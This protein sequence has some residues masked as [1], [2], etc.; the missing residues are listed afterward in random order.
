MIVTK[1]KTPKMYIIK[2]SFLKIFEKR[3][4]RHYYFLEY[5][6]HIFHELSSP[7]PFEMFSRIRDVQVS[8]SWQGREEKLKL[9]L[10]W[11]IPRRFRPSLRILTTPSPNLEISLRSNASLGYAIENTLVV[12]E[13]GPIPALDFSDSSR[14]TIRDEIFRRAVPDW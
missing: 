7:E 12:H 2:F 11:G 5:S 6:P 4:S 8:Q 1:K 9:R 10:S 13:R 14:S 3:H